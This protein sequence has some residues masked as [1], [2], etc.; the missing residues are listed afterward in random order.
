MKKFAVK[1]ISIFFVL[2]FIGTAFSSIAYAE[3][4]DVETE[5]KTHANPDIVLILMESYFDPQK[6]FCE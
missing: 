6:L 4:A 5:E 3:V 2:L 1:F